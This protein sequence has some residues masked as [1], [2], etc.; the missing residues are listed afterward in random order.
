MGYPKHA[1]DKEDLEAEQMPIES[2]VMT[3][4]LIRLP[5]RQVLVVSVYIQ[6]LVAD[7]LIEVCVNIHKIISDTRRDARSVIY[8]VITGD[9]NRH[10]QL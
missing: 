6:G 8:V 10:N 7:A 1:L 9:F 5:E 3:V 2:L 4:A